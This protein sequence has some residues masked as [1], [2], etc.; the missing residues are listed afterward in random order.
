M[1]IHV[2]TMEDRIFTRR[3]LWLF[4]RLIPALYL[5]MGVKFL[6]LRD[7]L[8]AS[9]GSHLWTDFLAV[10][11]AGNQAL[12]HGAA[13]IYGI[14]ALDALQ[15]SEVSNLAGLHLPFAYPPTFLL[16]ASPLGK[17]PYIA[18][19]FVW[20][21]A[22]L[23]LFVAAIYLII[24]RREA[25]V[26]ALAFPAVFSN[27]FVGQ[28]GLLAA[29]LLGTTLALLERRPVLAGVLLGCLTFRP[30]L[31]VL[32]PVVLILTGRW[33]TIVSTIITTF[34]MTGA[35]LWCFGPDA[36]RSFFAHAPE[37]A[38]ATL[39]QGQS[40]GSWS[41]LQSVYALVRSLGGTASLAW[42]SQIILAAVVVL[43]VS[44]VWTQ[45]MRYDLKAAALALG[46][47]TVTPYLYFYDLTI[48]AVPAAFLVVDGLKH[49]FA[50]FERLAILAGALCTVTFVAGIY[51]PL[52][53]FI[54]LLFAVVVVVRLRSRDMMSL[55][56]NAGS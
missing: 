34:G 25:M 33:R 13:S 36:W 29:A 53:P 2:G 46:S 51:A 50:R 40:V 30:Q 23:L 35:S 42:F 24:P 4:G 22:T 44:W 11:S 27:V 54:M 19:F 32:F 16:I 28:E 48:L 47:A 18:A 52:G 3:R 45:P 41:F 1:S 6:V 17:L 8:I 9:D 43:V 21:A 15:K 39:L 5:F 56:M 38:A 14:T 31:G 49:G 20:Q 12:H 10:W 26:L 55:A 7:W 37:H